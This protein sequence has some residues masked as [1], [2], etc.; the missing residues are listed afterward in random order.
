MA[1]VARAM[2]EDVLRGFLL[3]ADAAEILDDAVH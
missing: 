2:T 3:P 1:A